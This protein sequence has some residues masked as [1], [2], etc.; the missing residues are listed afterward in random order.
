[1]SAVSKIILTGEVVDEPGAYID[2]PD[3]MPMLMLRVKT[4]MK[5]P[6]REKEEVLYT[7]VAVFG[8]KAKDY[9]TRFA[10]GDRI[11]AEGGFRIERQEKNAQPRLV[12]DDTDGSI[13]QTT[14]ADDRN[15]VMLQGEALNVYV[16]VGDDSKGSFAAVNVKCSVDI[17]RDEPLS[18]I[19]NVIGFGHAVKMF[20]GLEKGQTVAVDSGRVSVRATNEKDDD[21][22]ET[23][24]FKTSVVVEEGISAVEKAA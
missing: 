14:R 24:V 15:T 6:A 11:D 12:I 19:H 17:G 13:E 7:S 1:M 4:T 9:A 10:K 3:K 22:K 18:I 8:D 20:Q 16:S 2:N 23:R 5:S 21:G